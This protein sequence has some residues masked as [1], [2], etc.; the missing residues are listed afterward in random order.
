MF[1][2]TLFKLINL[3]KTFKKKEL[4]VNF[5]YMKVHPILYV[6]QKYGVIYSYK[7]SKVNNNK[8]SIIARKESLMDVR[9]INKVMYISYYKL[10]SLIKKNPFCIF[11]ISTSIGIL[12]NEKILRLKLGG[13]FL[14][15]IKPK[16]ALVT[17]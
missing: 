3:L 16:N 11:I 10:S 2:K 14:F 12:D 4:V 15:I 13:Y 9:L 7:I 6:L 17:F 1:R 8:L 5:K